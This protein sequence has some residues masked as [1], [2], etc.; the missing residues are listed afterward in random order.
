MSQS[1]A[2][3]SP[4]T[5][6]YSS[7]SWVKGSSPHIFTDNTIC[8]QRAANFGAWE[9][10]LLSYTITSLTDDTS[11]L[12]LPSPPI[13]P[14]SDCFP[15]GI[16]ESVTPGVPSPAHYIFP[17]QRAPNSIPVPVTDPTVSM[18]VG[19][20]IPPPAPIMNMED[21]CQVGEQQYFEDSLPQ[22]FKSKMPQR[23]SAR[24]W[25]TARQAHT[26][27][28]RNYR[29]RLNAK[30]SDLSAYLFNESI[31]CQFLPNNSQEFYLMKVLTLYSRHQTKQ[32]DSYFAGYRSSFTSGETKPRIVIRG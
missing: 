29:D 32:V 2:C 3:F 16:P 8:P 13:S 25:R 10:P 26:I 19:G 7:T 17:T 27:I 9:G 21:D 23:S 14:L 18:Y 5:H 30:I 11:T 31:S 24:S 12:Q 1:Y 6:S 28:E 22:S 4:E 15:I 20:P